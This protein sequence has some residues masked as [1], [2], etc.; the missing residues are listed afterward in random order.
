MAIERPKIMTVRLSEDEEAFR[1][2]LAERL[3]SDGS[4]VMRQGMI[5]LGIQKGL[6]FPLKRQRRP[7]PKT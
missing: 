3:G 5:E 7:H 6:D 1:D 4:A 2:A